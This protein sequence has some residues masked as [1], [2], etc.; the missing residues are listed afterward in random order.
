[1]ADKK[2]FQV[3]ESL[4][5]REQIQCDYCYRDA[6]MCRNRRDGKRNYMCQSCSGKEEQK[7]HCFSCMDISSD[8]VP[9]GNIYGIVEMVCQQCKN[10]CICSRH[11][12]LTMNGVCDECELYELGCHF[13]DRLFKNHSDA[14]LVNSNFKNF[15]ALVCSKCKSSKVCPKD[16]VILEKGFCLKCGED[17]GY[18]E[19][20]NYDAEYF[21]E[22]EYIDSDSE[23]KYPMTL[24][25]GC[26][27][28]YGHSVP[29]RKNN[30]ILDYCYNCFEILCCENCSRVKSKGECIYCSAPDDDSDED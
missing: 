8:L 30:T 28:D 27:D 11:K 9:V 23:E 29:V 16:N 26:K 5:D 17:F 15:S 13:C 21:A 18:S 14:H 24:D 12:S 3:W 1:M 6:Y 2:V 10:G 20:I 4:E 19:P 25:C 22:D 7:E